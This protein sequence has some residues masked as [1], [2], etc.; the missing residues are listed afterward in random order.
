MAR[1]QKRCYIYTRVSTAMQVDGYSLDAQYNKLCDYAKYQDMVVVKTYSDEGKS[2]KNLEGRPSFRQMLRDIEDGVD[3]VDFVLVM[4]LSRFGRNASDV[5]NSLQLMQDCDVNLISVD[6]GIDSSKEAGKL[7]IS[8]LAAVAEIER[9]NILAQ[10]MEGRKQKAR[11]GKWNGGFAPYGYKLVDG[12]LEIAED[13][14][15][16]IRVIYD[17]YVNTAMGVNKLAVF[18]NRNGYVKKKR[19]N[20]TLDAFAATFVK[21]VLD[22]PVYYGKMAYG[23]R[24]TEKIPGEHNKFHVVKQDEFPVYEGV[25]EAIVSEDLWMRAQAK[26]KANGRKWDKVYSPGHEHILSGIV[27]CPICGAGMYGNVNRKKKK[28]GTTYKDYWYYACKHRLEIDGH[29]CPYHKQWSE[30][31]V[32]DAVVEAIREMVSVP[33]FTEAIKKKIGSTIDTQQL[34]K[35]R[36]TLKKQIRKTLAAKDRLAEQM[37][38]LDVSDKHYSRKHQDMESRLDALYDEIAEMEERIEEVSMRMENILRQKVSSEHV[39]KL[40]E[41]FDEV[42]EK[43]TDLEKKELMGSLIESVELYEDVQ[44]NGKFLRKITFT[45]PIVN[46][47]RQVDIDSW[48]LDSTVETVCLMSRVEEK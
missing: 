20:N 7:I 33:Q 26:R 12:Y 30:D 40:L 32:N 44:P 18:L 15:E 23:R 2:G 14:A 22:N 19:Q 47:G 21:S 43:A 13:E 48:E 28:D 45:F 29:V 34:E 46:I 8:V 4:K 42:Y 11:E 3:D 38:H 41:R 31:K 17:K 24:K 27:K 5:L 39:Y 6:D 10:T 1:K 36:E 16:V 25:H 35:E 9:E 37:D